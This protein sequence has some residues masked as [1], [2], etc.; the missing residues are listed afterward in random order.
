MLLPEYISLAEIHKIIEDTV[1]KS[2]DVEVDFEELRV[3]LEI[4]R[5]PDGEDILVV[6]ER[7]LYLS[8]FRAVY[9]DSWAAGKLEAALHNSLIR[10][11]SPSWYEIRETGFIRLAPNAATVA[12][13]ILLDCAKIYDRLLAAHLSIVPRPTE[14][15]LFEKNAFDVQRDSLQHFGFKSSQLLEIL[16]REGV[17]Y[18]FDQGTPEGEKKVQV[19]SSA[20]MGDLQRIEKS[21]NEAGVIVNKLGYSKNLVNGFL[22]QEHI[23][24][25]ERLGFEKQAHLVT[26]IWLRLIAAS[27]GELEGER[28]DDVEPYIGGEELKRIGSYSGK[29]ITKNS[30]KNHVH[31]WKNK[32]EQKNSSTS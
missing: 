31:R 12:L 29:K 32:A 7:K 8:Y 19:Q 3:L 10:G 25:R 22:E 13:P 2:K 26:E 28:L 6:F 4:P 15:N 5:I 1:K 9:Y 11:D 20:L 27:K 21:T 14:L 18:N 30:I 16:D 24:I 23:R 17:P